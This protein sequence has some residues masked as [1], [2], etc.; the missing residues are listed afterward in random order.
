VSKNAGPARR[1]L[2][3][4]VNDNRGQGLPRETSERLWTLTNKLSSRLS[5]MK[6]EKIEIALLIEL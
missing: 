5:I 4:V 6:D 1:T 2:S 3:A